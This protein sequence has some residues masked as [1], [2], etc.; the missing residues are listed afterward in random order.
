MALNPYPISGAL[1]AQ[2]IHFRDDFISASLSAENDV[3]LKAG[4]TIGANGL[5]L[6]G[7][8]YAYVRN[9]R[10]FTAPAGFTVYIR[11]IPTF[12]LNDGDNKFF[13][14]TPGDGRC[15]FYISGTGNISIRCGDVFVASVL[16]ANYEAYYTKDAVNEW[17]LTSISGDTNLW[18]NGTQI[19]TSDSTTYTWNDDAR[20]TYLGIQSSLA[21]GF[22]GT[23]DR[24][25][26]WDRP[27]T[28]ADV[29]A[30]TLRD[31]P[32]VEHLSPGSSVLATSGASK[33][34]GGLTFI[35]CYGTSEAT[36]GVLGVNGTDTA[37]FPDDDVSR[38]GFVFDG[39]NDLVTIPKVPGLVFTDGSDLPFSIAFAFRADTLANAALLG[40]AGTSASIDEG[41]YIVHITSTGRLHF[42]LI[43]DG[44]GYLGRRTASSRIILGHYH[45]V[46]C[47]YTGSG[48]ASGI[49]IYIDG[50]VA[51]G[52]TTGAGYTEMSETSYDFTVGK[53]LASLSYFNGYV[54]PVFV[55]GH[56]L[57]K[58]EAESFSHMLSN[59]YAG[60]VR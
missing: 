24:F 33:T 4:A 30:I 10:L 11:C 28:S 34:V 58:V 2:G 31:G 21:G 17:I 55:F 47:T 3:E 26:V 36:K 57:C 1:H 51:D 25:Y 45:T 37:N 35:E 14:D 56:A 48:L 7:T 42:E 5:T 15:W 19:L 52:A 16:K 23:I 50:I 18:L 49:D 29:D 40:R 9:R 20:D 54:S 44:S 32:T 12:E 22:K 53:T 39:S 27:I 8:E 41:E 43:D 13:Y 6:T 59:Y 60:S 46:V 38:L